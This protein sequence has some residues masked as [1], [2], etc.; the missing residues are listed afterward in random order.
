MKPIK[1]VYRKKWKVWALLFIFGIFTLFCFIK[2]VR[3]A[4]I[5]RQQTFDV[6][7]GKSADGAS[8][9]RFAASGQQ[10]GMDQ[11]G[12]RLAQEENL[13]QEEP[14]EFVNWTQTEGTLISAPELGTMEECEALVL[15]GRSDILFPGYAVL[16]MEM[17]DDCLIS[18]ALSGKLFG[19]EHISGVTVEVQGR[20]M[21]V[22]DVID[23]EESFLVY[24]AGEQDTFLFDRAAV[25]CVPGKYSKAAERFQELCGVWEQMESRVMV[26]TAQAVC[27]LVP[28][29]L[30]IFCVVIILQNADAIDDVSISEIPFDTGKYVEAQKA[31]RRE[32]MVWKALAYLLL[33]GGIL[34]LI[35]IVRI[36]EDMIPARWSDF[37]F[38]TEYGKNMGEAC[39]LLIRSEKRIPDMMMIKEFA[40]ALQWGAAAIVGE[41]GFC[42][43]VMGRI[44]FRCYSILPS[45]K[46]IRM[47]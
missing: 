32:K 4:E 8:V 37:S 30:W 44:P 15:G 39:K 41:M 43:C 29:M 6:I 17:Q 9:L 35:R 40:G 22:L 42:V 16:D 10:G 23:S 18:S 11:T 12:T 33:A 46:E 27:F 19:G 45:K 14:L 26:W 36:P 1:N 13:K 7:C 34:L 21:E 31:G 28:C 5:L 20:K 25:K 3:H 38:W 2:A 47:F 24:E